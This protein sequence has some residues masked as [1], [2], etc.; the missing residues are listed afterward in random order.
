MALF[1]AMGK[2]TILEFKVATIYS[3]KRTHMHYD[4]PHPHNEV[5]IY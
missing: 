2:R 4:V 3:D 5:A 1:F